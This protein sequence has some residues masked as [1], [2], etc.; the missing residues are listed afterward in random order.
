MQAQDVRLFQAALGLSE[1]WQVVSVEFDPAAK[2]LDLRI[3]FAKDARFAC[4]ECGREDCAV[5]DT[6]EKTWRHLDFFQQCAA[7]RLVVSPAQPGWTRR[8]VLESDGLPGS[9]R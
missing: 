7:R 1:P 2:R 8:V 9:E 6:E 4:P 3:D 5:H